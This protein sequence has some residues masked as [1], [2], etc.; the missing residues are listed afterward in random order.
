MLELRL[1]NVQN[2]VYGGGID[3]LH[4]HESVILQLI[5]ELKDIQA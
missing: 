2:K 4:A 1:K 3:M 5:N